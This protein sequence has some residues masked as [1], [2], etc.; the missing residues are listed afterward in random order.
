MTYTRWQ[1]FTDRAMGFV[2][3]VLDTYLSVVP[4]RSVALEY[5]DRFDADEGIVSP[6]CSL[7]I[8]SDSPY[9]APKAFSE[10]APWHSR[11]GWFDSPTAQLRRLINIDVQIADAT[12]APHTTRRVAQIRSMMR[13]IFNQPG[14]ESLENDQVDAELLASRF[15][16]IHLD[17]NDLLGKVIT[18]EAAQRIALGKVE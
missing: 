13:E 7:L 9:I 8:R 14:F 5:F 18:S 11:A 12:V 15:N 16:S 3:A 1:A 17:L 4:L 2:A 10:T 6:K